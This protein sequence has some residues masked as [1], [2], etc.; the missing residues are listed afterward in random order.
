MGQER[1]VW[2]LP[3]DEHEFNVAP[4]SASTISFSSAALSDSERRSSG[5]KCHPLMA[6]RSP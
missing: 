1:R 2:R 5:S 3:L 6:R 4:V